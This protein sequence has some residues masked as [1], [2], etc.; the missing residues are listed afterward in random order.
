MQMF[1]FVLIKHHGH[2]KILCCKSHVKIQGR[3]NMW[4]YAFYAQLHCVNKCVT[5]YFGIEYFF[6]LSLLSGYK[7]LIN[8]SF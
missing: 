7:H 4:A 5:E 1:V 6:H 3:L 2:I 8:L